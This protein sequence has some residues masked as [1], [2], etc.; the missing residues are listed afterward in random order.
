MCDQATYQ[1][2]SEACARGNLSSHILDCNSFDDKLRDIALKRNSRADTI[3]TLAQLSQKDKKQ[4][5]NDLACTGKYK[6]IFSPYDFKVSNYHKSR[7]T[8]SFKLENNARVPFKVEIET[9]VDTPMIEDQYLHL[10]FEQP[11]LDP[12]Y[13]LTTITNF[14]DANVYFE[15]CHNPGIR[16]LPHYTLEING[17]C[18][19]KIDR[20]QV[21]LYDK[22]MV[23]ENQLLLWK[24]LI[25]ED[26]GCVCSADML[27]L[28]VRQ[29]YK[30]YAGYQTKK[31]VH[32]N[33][34]LTIPLMFDVNENGFNTGLIREHSAFVKGEFEKSK[35][36]VRAVYD[37]GVLPAIPL[38]VSPL[39]IRC[40][41]IISNQSR[42]SDN[43]NA[44]LLNMPDKRLISQIEVNR[45]KLSDLDTP[46]ELKGD[47]VL[48][49]ICFYVTPRGY[50]EDFDLWDR[51]EEVKKHCISVPIMSFDVNGIPG[52][53]SV[54]PAICY[55]SA[56]KVKNVE[57]KWKDIVLKE[58]NDAMVYQTL[59][60][61]NMSKYLNEFR[62][63]ATDGMYIM[64]FNSFLYTTKINGVL[65]LSG[66]KE[67]KLII[68]FAEDL[69]DS[70]NNCLLLEYDVTVIRRHFNVIMNIGSTITQVYVQK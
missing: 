5:Y 14:T 20:E 37:D 21:M 23:P 31:N 51:Y 62:P 44:L 16:L 55:E 17:D 8:T 70:I 59:Q 46:I 52:Q 12:T 48:E 22:E 4:I 58:K 26:T 3:D 40:A 30:F 61:F 43:L 42:F 28:E 27:D 18:V 54:Q 65:N 2:L 32:P 67:P 35:L 68:E 39:S 53:V 34:E 11:K 69:I 50:A 60:K 41:R 7:F 6:K 63:T 25:G 24:K 47:G 49:A 33:L 57:L 64:S 56:S 13:D 19:E 1:L 29:E 38:P 15:Y 10:I 36:I 66:V 9:N 45:Y